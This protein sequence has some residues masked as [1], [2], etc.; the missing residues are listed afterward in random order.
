MYLAYSENG[1]QY[2]SSRLNGIFTKAKKE[3]DS[4]KD[5]YTSTEHLL[6]A[7]AYNEAGMSEAAAAELD[8]LRKQN[9]EAAIVAALSDSLRP[10]RP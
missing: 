6:L 2:I 8:A 1:Q 5:E 9:P 10:S 3:A 7:I 4:L